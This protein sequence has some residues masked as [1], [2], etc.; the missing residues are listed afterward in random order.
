MVD[1][2]ARAGLLEDAEKFIEEKV[3]GIGKG[4]ANVWGAF[5]LVHVEFMGTL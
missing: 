3:G 1:L 4:D 2:L 5:Y